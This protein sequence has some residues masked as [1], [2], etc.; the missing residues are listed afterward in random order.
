MHLQIF[1]FPLSSAS[2]RGCKSWLRFFFFFF[3]PFLN[4][5]KLSIYL[6]EWLIFMF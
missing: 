6:H 2:F 3:G 1:I 4:H 5:P